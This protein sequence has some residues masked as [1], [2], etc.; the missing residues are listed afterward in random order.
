MAW[1]MP[2]TRAA[3]PAE[4]AEQRRAYKREWMRKKRAV[5][6][7]GMERVTLYFTRSKMAEIQEA[8]APGMTK[9]QAV[10]SLVHLALE[11]MRKQ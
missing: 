10:E 3:D 1:R 11:R 6:G 4:R 9:S 2:E 7:A 8:A 5:Q